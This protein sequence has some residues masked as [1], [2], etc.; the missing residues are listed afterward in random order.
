MIAFNGVNKQLVCK[1]LLVSYSHLGEGATNFSIVFLHGW[2]S[3]KEVWGQQISWSADK[4]VSCYALDL[5]GFGKS[6][7]PSIPMTVGDYAEI[8]KEFIQKLELE[9]VIIVGHSFGGRIGIKFASKYPGQI[10]K[11]VLVDSAGFAIS[12][13]KKS[14]MNIVAK[15][16]KPFFKP[17]FMQGLKKRIYKAMGSE[18]YIATPEL[19]KTYIKIIEE[20]LTEDMKQ[21]KCPTL[22]ITGENDTDTPISFGQRMHSLI[23]NSKF[24]ILL[25]AGHFSFVDQP[26]FFL[27]QLVDFI[28]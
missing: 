24:T 3:N 26:Q 9:N 1:N 22:I 16:V 27:E 18:D 7:T 28:K 14:A 13:D 5:P 4:L 2:R 25:K 21:I 6:Q 11:L 8:V 19:Q 15:I 17:K 12:G 23:Q 20:D 10:N